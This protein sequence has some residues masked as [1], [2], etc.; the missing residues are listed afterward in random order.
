M[1]EFLVHVSQ[2]YHNEKVGKFLL[3]EDKSFYDWTITACFYSAIHFIEARLFCD[4]TDTKNR[5]SETSMPVENDGKFKYSPHSWRAKFVFEN[6]SQ[7]TW[8]SFRSLKEASETARYLSHYAD[9]TP[10]S[11]TFETVPSFNLFTIENAK[12]ALEKDLASIKHELKISLIEFL[13]DLGLEKTDWLK[14]AVITPK[15]IRN[16]E[17]GDKFLD[18]TKDSLRRCLSKEEIEFIE[19]HLIKKGLSFKQK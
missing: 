19:Q 18:E 10:E 4:S 1:A 6:Y 17:T 15:I 2:A 5:H 14:S 3:G 11:A 9:K 7:N 16:F 12:F 8:K 13:F